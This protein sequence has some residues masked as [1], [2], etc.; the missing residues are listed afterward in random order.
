MMVKPSMIASM[1]LGVL[2]FFGLL[3]GAAYFGGHSA[4]KAYGK[5]TGRNVR[6]NAQVGCLVETSTGW[7]P[8]EELRQ[9]YRVNP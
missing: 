2:L 5:E 9:V 3:L 8:R 7:L 4:C 1:A 6:Y